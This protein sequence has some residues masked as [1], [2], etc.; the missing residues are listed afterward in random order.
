MTFIVQDDNGD[1]EGANAYITIEFLRDFHGSRGRDLTANLDVDLQTAIVRAT[2]YLDQR[3]N[4]VG[5]RYSEDQTTSWP[6][7]NARHFD[8]WYV[9]DIPDA[10]KRATAEYAYI[11][12]QQELNPSPDRDPSG[13]QV[14]SKTDKVG[15]ITESVSYAYGGGFSMPKYPIADRILLKSGLALAVGRVQ[16]G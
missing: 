5:R 15:P 10:V 6:R 11:A 8:G 13:L 14:S 9:C 7:L 4:F 12:L 16:R 3:F 1:V 2:D